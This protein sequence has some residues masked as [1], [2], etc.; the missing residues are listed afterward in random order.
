MSTASIGND[1]GNNDD[2][3]PIVAA[4]ASDFDKSNVPENVIDNTHS[5]MWVSKSMGAWIKLDLGDIK[6]IG[7]IGISWYKG[8]EGRKYSFNIQT[9]IDDYL[10]GDLYSDK[11]IL[12][13]SGTKDYEVYEFP[14]GKEQKQGQQNSAYSPASSARYIKIIVNGNN[15]DDSAA[16]HTVKVLR[17]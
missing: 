16:I 5:T 17:P 3:Y 2:V 11:R 14:N 12:T 10:Y 7:G 13:N 6:R 8:D 15:K 1:N 4:T 9:S